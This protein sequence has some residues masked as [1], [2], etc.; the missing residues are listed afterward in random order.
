MFM[1]LITVDHSNEFFFYLIDIQSYLISYSLPLLRNISS[2]LKF[3]YH[4]SPFY[5]GF[6]YLRKQRLADSSIMFLDL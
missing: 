2:F 6:L 5:A 3:A 1:L 4:K